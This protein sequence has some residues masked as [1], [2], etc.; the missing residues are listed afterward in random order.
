VEYKPFK[1]YPDIL[2]LHATAGYH[3]GVNNP[4]GAMKDDHL[5]INVGAKMNFDILRGLRWALKK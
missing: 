1:K 4:Q 5:L 2:R 3:W